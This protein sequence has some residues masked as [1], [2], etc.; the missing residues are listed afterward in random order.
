MS[1]HSLA[2]IYQA[3]TPAIE[4]DVTHA[5]AIPIHRELSLKTYENTM[6]A[7]PR[8]GTLPSTGRGFDS[9]SVA[10]PSR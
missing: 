1:R 9:P 8:R 5:G 4:G 2:R 7:T 10:L 6:V 3:A